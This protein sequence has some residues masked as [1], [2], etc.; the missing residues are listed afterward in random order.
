MKVKP[1]T[2]YI[3]A[4]LVAIILIVVF[5]GKNSSSDEVVANPHGEVSDSKMPND[6]V[7]SGMSDMGSNTP[8]KSNVSEDFYARMNELKSK[9]EENPNDTLSM[10]ELGHFNY[11]SHKTDEAMALYNKIL[12]IDNKRTDIHFAVG[13]IYYNDRR[14]DLAE[15][16][17]NT[18]LGYD[19]DNTVAIYNL[20]AISQ[21]SG[22]IEKAKGYW[23]SI[24]QKYP[25]SHEAF[26][27]QQSLEQIKQG[28]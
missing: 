17:M 6:D 4:F 24:I 14:F 13:V 19:N 5:S 2:I 20:G 28:K 1:V 9:I 18:V 15:E 23:Q 22:D 26:L 21:G 3:A 16:K 25:D 8:S 12:S 11:M 7:H 10:K 27:A